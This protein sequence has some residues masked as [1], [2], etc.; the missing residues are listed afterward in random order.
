VAQQAGAQPVEIL[1]LPASGEV[2]LDARASDRALRVSWH[3]EDGVVVLSLWRADRCS[4][5][6]R[7]PLAEVPGLVNTLVSGLVRAAD[8]REEHYQPPLPPYVV[9]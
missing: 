1:A 5:T 3:S 2:F 6:F 9:P 7:L 4:G 8:S